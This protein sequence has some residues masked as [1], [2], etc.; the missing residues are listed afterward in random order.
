MKKNNKVCKYCDNGNI[1]E[2]FICV[3]CGTGMCQECYDNMVEHENHMFDFSELDESEE[4]LNFLYDRTD[5]HGDY[6]C[7]DCLSKLKKEF[8][9]RYSPYC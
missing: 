9:T 7:Y 8:G 3:N 4:F 1:A 6:M 5:S 2:Y